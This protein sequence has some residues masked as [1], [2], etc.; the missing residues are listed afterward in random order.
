MCYRLRTLMIVLALIASMALMLIPGCGHLSDD[1]DA[2]YYDGFMFYGTPQGDFFACGVY[3]KEDG[4]KK[5]FVSFRGSPRKRL[6]DLTWDDFV[7]WNELNANKGFHFS[8][9]ADHGT[10]DEGSS[11]YFEKGQLSRVEITGSDLEYSGSESGPTIEFTAIAGRGPTRKQI[12]AAFG[13]PLRVEK[14]GRVHGI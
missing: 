3:E 9:S 1:V 14:T 10:V 4:L 11:F 6:A 7:K 8:G 13:K 2:L 12:E 5:I